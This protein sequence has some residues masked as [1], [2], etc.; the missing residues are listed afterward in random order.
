MMKRDPVQPD[1]VLASLQNPRV[2]YVVKLRKRAVRDADNQLLIEGYREVSRALEN[3]YPARTVFFCPALFQGVN[4]QAL[5]GRARQAGADLIECTEPVFRKMAYRDRPEGLLAV[6]PQI[7]LGLDDLQPGGQG[8]WLVAEA[9]EKPGNLGSILRSADAA[10]A[11]GVIVCDPCTDIHNPN[12]VRA[13]IGTLFCLP[14]AVARRDETIA[15]LKRNRI[16]TVAATPAA[17]RLYSDVDLR[18]ATALVVGAEQ[19]GL[20]AAWLENPEAAVRIPM[21]GKAD[22]LNVANAATIL[23]FEAVRQRQCEAETRDGNGV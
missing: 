8:L 15:W 2:K 14:V 7:R 22:S 16:Q 23:L 20:S 13:S 3:R 4:E 12:T 10:G 18:P 19:W 17:D 6:G 1:D 5:L 9:I 11:G 21:R